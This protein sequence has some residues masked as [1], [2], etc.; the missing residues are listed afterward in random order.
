M[1]DV[2]YRSGTDPP[3]EW[4]PDSRLALLGNTSKILEFVSLADS[5]VSEGWARVHT[6]SG[7]LRGSVRFQVVGP[8]GSLEEDV[9]IFAASR[10][11]KFQTGFRKKDNLSFAIVNVGES[12]IPINI[13]LV[14]NDGGNP[15][16][17]EREFLD[18][19]SMWSFFLT[20]P[21]VFGEDI[22]IDEGTL[23]IE[24]DEDDPTTGSG[25]I[26][27]GLVNRDVGFF[28]SAQSISRIR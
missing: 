7:L 9:A 16:D 27:I 18:P 26:L 25:I 22:P 6:A 3:I 8:D 20:S 10:G 11:R 21:D 19:G 12:R 24:I 4:T 1:E 15:E 13:D 23:L 14:E 17:G 28:I 5:G 2:G